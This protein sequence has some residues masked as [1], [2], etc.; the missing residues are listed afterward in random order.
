[1]RCQVPLDSAI[2]S[3]ELKWLASG[4][5][6]QVRRFVAYNVNGYKFRTI[7]KEERMKMQNN[8][9]YVTSDTRSY[10]SKRD[11]HV[12]IEARLVYYVEDVVEKEWSV[13]V[14]VNPRDLFDMGEDYEQTEVVFF[15]NSGLKMFTGDDIGDLHLA[16]KDEFEDLTNNSRDTV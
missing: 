13:V 4:P 5:M 9:V 16:R 12:A 8:G 15:P 10:A 2:H 1:M 7:A 14:H 11:N 6:I 3:N